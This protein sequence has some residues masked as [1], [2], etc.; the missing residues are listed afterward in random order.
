MK[1]ILTLLVIVIGFVCCTGVVQAEDK[2]REKKVL[3]LGIDGCRFDALQAANTPHLDSLIENGCYHDGVLILGDRYRENDT[4]SGPGWSSI[5][6]GVWADK[7]GVNDNKFTGKNYEQYPHLFVR[8]KSVQPESET[9]SMI[10]WEPI[11]EHI[12]AGADHSESVVPQQGNYAEADRVAVRSVTRML[13]TQDPTLVFYYIG[14]VDETGHK[15]GF[16]P[17]VQPYVEAIERADEIVG[18][19]LAAV[20]ARETYDQEEWLILVTSDHGG[21]GTGHSSGHNV[22]E[23]LNSFAIISGEATT[24]GKL[25]GQP[26]LVD[27]PVTALHFLGVPIDPQWKLDG[28]PIGLKSE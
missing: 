14:Q 24:R 9:Y 6:T 27:V 17:T 16:H 4:I 18:Q 1:Q 8:L 12:V 11:R 21:R 22:P 20:R 19:V 28:Q 10:T 2:P 5:L 25:S 13:A 15:H 26:Y 23:I 7:H 3:F